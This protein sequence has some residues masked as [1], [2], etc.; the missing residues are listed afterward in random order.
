MKTKE[1]KRLEVKLT[2][3]QKERLQAKAN[4]N[5]NG[6]LSEL[7]RMLADGKEIK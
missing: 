5:S 4:K 6:N 3:K 1:Y 2:E 7:V